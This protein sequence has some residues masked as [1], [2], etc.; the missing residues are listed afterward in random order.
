M[1]LST[2]IIWL[3]N[4]CDS[5]A[6]LQRIYEQAMVLDK[7][8]FPWILLNVSCNGS[9]NANFSNGILDILQ[10]MKK[11]LKTQTIGTSQSFG[12]LLT[13]VGEERWCSP[14]TVF[15]HHSYAIPFERNFYEQSSLEELNTIVKDL[16]KLEGDSREFLQAQLGSVGYKKLMKD[17]NANNHKDLIFDAKKALSYNLVHKIGFLEPLVIKVPD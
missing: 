13:A 6:G 8:D 3:G 15:M 12:I 2:N 11:P 4:D 1:Q 9:E 5:D 14:R 7:S 16:V 17:F 10:A